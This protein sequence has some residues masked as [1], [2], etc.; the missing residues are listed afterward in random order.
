MSLAPAAAAGFHDASAYDAHRPSYPASAVQALLTHMRLA[1]KPHARIVE[2]AAGT[3][4]F[5]EVLAARHEGFEVIAVEPHD[6]MRAALEAKG[7]NGVSVRAGRAEALREAMKGMEGKEEE[8]EGWADGVVVAQA[9]HWFAGEE[10]L[11]ELGG[12]LKTGGVLGL[13]WNIDDC[14]CEACDVAESL[15]GEGG[16]VLR[17]KLHISLSFFFLSFFVSWSLVH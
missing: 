15:S 8:E 11:G 16:G 4:K 6:E 10:A 7:L 9:F 12:V 3:G 17:Q 5:T 1:D 13:V 14:K 2:V